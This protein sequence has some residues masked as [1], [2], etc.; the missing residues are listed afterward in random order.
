[1]NAPSKLNSRLEEL[2]KQYEKTLPQKL[3]KIEQGWSK[4][5]QIN[6][7]EALLDKLTA[8]AHQ[9]AGSG[10]TFGFPQVSIEARELETLLGN[11]QAKSLPPNSQEKAQISAKV[12]ELV[13]ALAVVESPTAVAEQ[14]PA[15]RRKSVALVDSDRALVDYLAEVVAAWGYE[16]SGFHRLEDFFE[17]VEKKNPDLACLDVV[18]PTGKVAGISA[19]EVI[20]RTSKQKV[21]VVFISSRTDMVARLKALRVGCQGYLTKPA[22]EAKLRGII[23]SALQAEH[24]QQVLIID[25]DELL[26]QHNSQVLREAGYQTAWITDPVNTLEKLQSF[27]PDVIVMDYHMPH[28]NGLELAQ[29]LRQDDRYMGIPIVFLSSEQSPDIQQRAYSITGNAFLT[30]P[31]D[32]AL[33]LQHV[34]DTITQ[35]KT[36]RSKLD[37]IR[38]TQA[39]SKLSTKSYFLAQ[40]E[41]AIQVGGDEQACRFLLYIDIQNADY[42]KQR[43]GM[44]AYSQLEEQLGHFLASQVGGDLITQFRGDLYLV[45]TKPVTQEVGIEL[46][47][48]LASLVQQHEF[49]LKKTTLHIDINVGMTGIDLRVNSIEQSLTDAEQ[50]CAEAG[51]RGK[52]E[53]VVWPEKDLD[54]PAEALE[55]SLD[56]AVQQA[57]ESKSFQLVFQPVVNLERTE[58]LFECRLRL[59]TG[60]GKVLTP[61]QFMPFVED[62]RLQLQLDRWVV[63]KSI[64]T[65]SNLQGLDR[66]EINLALKVS[67]VSYGLSQIVNYLGNALRN[68]KVKGSFRLLVE[69][70]ESWA[71]SKQ[72]TIV[73][74]IKRL[75][76]VGIGFLLDRVGETSHSIE[77]IKSLQ[78]NFVKLDKH[79][80]NTFKDE[81]ESKQRIEEIVA[82]AKETKTQVVAGTIEDAKVFAALWDMGIR[83]FHGYFIQQPESHLDFDFRSFGFG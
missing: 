21:P 80:I 38:R 51:K 7:S 41:T 19:V 33:L 46:G 74:E 8:L 54:I 62:N 25:D 27:A 63:Q 79:L 6:W 69:V 76:S 28:C 4:L 14:P 18:Y 57:I 59:H 49:A 34:R 82:L 30:K 67:P 40:L 48:R 36:I 83:Y 17:A 2:R 60:N 42:H 15:T 61:N 37:L 43:L 47:Q 11:L 24:S 64:E 31:V 68:S 71:I 56:D 77:L 72:D 5:C 10:K 73:Q 13:G 3:E 29:L 75:N 44:V 23:D 81:P 16:V 35:S 20:R 78:P 70:D 1:M 9:L 26:A 52:G 45:L 55:F 66:E 39:G 53:V 32:D 65:L 58:K 50:G 12:A 22:D